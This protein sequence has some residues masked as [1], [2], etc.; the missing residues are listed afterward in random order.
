MNIAILCMTTPYTYG[1]TETMLHFI[2]AAMKKGHQITG[3]YFY[4]DGVL[5]NN[6]NITPSD[7]KEK[8]IATLIKEIV[9]KGVPVSSCPI[10]A[11]Y[12][13]VKDE[14]L[15]IDQTSFEGLAYLTELVMDSD[16]LLA[17]TI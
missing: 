8:N 5:N 16:R 3:V 12:R 1:N 9:D 2:D 17:F 7:E 6:K 10:C 15:L 4:M 11:E 14:S 13:G